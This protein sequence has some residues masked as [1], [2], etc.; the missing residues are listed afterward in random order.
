M[1]YS[2]SLCYPKPQ[3]P[4]PQNEGDE[5]CDCP[6]LLNIRHGAVTP[7]RFLQRTVLEIPIRNHIIVSICQQ[8]PHCPAAL[9]P[10]K[11]G[12]IRHMIIKV[13]EELS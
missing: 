3:S 8:S 9:T 13:Q 1:I 6:A 4:A 2:V 5:A 7:H 12:R 11:T 10:A